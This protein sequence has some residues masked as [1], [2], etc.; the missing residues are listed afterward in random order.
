MTYHHGH[1]SEED[2]TWRV[3]AFEARISKDPLAVA[4]RLWVKNRLDPAEEKRRFST[5][6]SQMHEAFR[7]R[8]GGF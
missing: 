6:I 4:D 1:A 2:L 7:D 5:R 8:M 3:E